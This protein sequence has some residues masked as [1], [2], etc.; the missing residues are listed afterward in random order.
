MDGNQRFT[1][2]LNHRC[3]EI[4]KHPLQNFKKI[5]LLWHPYRYLLMISTHYQY[6]VNIFSRFSRNSKKISRC[7]SSVLHHYAC[8]TEEIFLR[9]G[10]KFTSILLESFE[11][12]CLLVANSKP[13]TNSRILSKNE[14]YEFTG[15]ITMNNI[16]CCIWLVKSASHID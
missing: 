15:I 13:W 3:I 14:L 9:I 7:V 16:N 5:L 1:S 12:F 4:L 11:Y 2:S 10:L 6:P 8:G